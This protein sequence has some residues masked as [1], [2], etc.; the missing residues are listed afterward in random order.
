MST[1]PHGAPRPL[2]DR[3]NLLHL[4]AQA[5]DLFKAGA[6]GSLTDAQFQAA[7]S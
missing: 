3:R 7:R 1:D 5:R 4:K 6:A 2:P